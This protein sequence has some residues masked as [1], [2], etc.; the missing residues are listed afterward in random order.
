ML[1]GGSAYLPK[2]NGISFKWHDH[3]EADLALLE[4]TPPLSQE[5]WD[6]HEF[7]AAMLPSS[8]LC[9]DGKP[10]YFMGWG[11]RAVDLM[12][13]PPHRRM[14]M[15]KG[16]LKISSHCENTSI[17]NKFNFCVLQKEND[18]FR[19]CPG[20]SGG[21]LLSPDR[22]VLGI[23]SKGVQNKGGRKCPV[24][25]EHEPSSVF[26]NVCHQS[27]QDFLRSKLPPELFNQATLPGQEDV[28]KDIHTRFEYE[29]DLRSYQPLITDVLL[30]K[31]QL[32]WLLLSMSM[33]CVCNMYCWLL[34][35][36]LLLLK[37]PPQKKF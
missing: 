2:R 14:Y 6:S 22:R 19:T 31:N 20:D 34:C 13:V 12:D 11:V 10:G 15:N 4:L 27:V 18:N 24:G 29:E 23:Q 17:K 25:E 28:F 8:D 3:P 9:N 30:I 32:F 36:L 33:F 1:E 35:V 37:S 5:V 21:A 16:I 7:C 26:V